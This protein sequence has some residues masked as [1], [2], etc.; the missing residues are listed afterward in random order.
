MPP[1]IDGFR[2]ALPILRGAFVGYGAQKGIDRFV[3]RTPS[4]PPVVIDGDPTRYAERQCWQV[5]CRSRAGISVQAEATD[6]VTG[7]GG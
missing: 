6:L 2:S 5:L 7:R 3:T 4:L 1:P